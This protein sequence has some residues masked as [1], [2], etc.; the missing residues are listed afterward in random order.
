MEIGMRKCIA[1]CLLALSITC[2]A[3]SDMSSMSSEQMA[4]MQKCI[5]N[6]D[7]SAVSEIEQRGGEMAKEI[8]ALCLNGKR[9]EAADKGLIFANEIWN[10]AELSAIRNC[11]SKVTSASPPDASDKNSHICDG[12]FGLMR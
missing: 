10:S 9:S 3:S 1:L 12:K 7:F 5:E 8:H 2:Q 11:A 6:V 4:A